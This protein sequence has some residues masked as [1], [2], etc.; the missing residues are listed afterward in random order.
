MTEPEIMDRSYNGWSG[1][2]IHMLDVEDNLLDQGEIHAIRYNLPRPN[3]QRPA[4]TL[5]AFCK[6]KFMFSALCKK[7]KTIR[8][9]ALNECN[10]C[11]EIK[12]LNVDLMPPNK[13]GFWFF[14]YGKITPW[15]PVEEKE[16]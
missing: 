2:C 3:L 8:L 16:K 11:L 7:C 13:E 5:I 6:N 14:S 4:G 10:D 9:R 12:L 1:V 15:K